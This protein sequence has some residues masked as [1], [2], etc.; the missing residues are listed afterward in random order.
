MEHKL[1]NEAA[2]EGK[3][4]LTEFVRIVDQVIGYANSANAELNAPTAVKL[5]FLY[6]I[7]RYS[8]FIARSKTSPE[9]QEAYIK[10]MADRYAAMMRE[11][12][13]DPTLRPPSEPR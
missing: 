11:H 5:A 6:G 8:A 1:A 3:V 4:H 9:D 10:E 12:F 7:A 2:E 13:A